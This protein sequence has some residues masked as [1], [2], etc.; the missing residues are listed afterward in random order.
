M[1]KLELSIKT[2]K[3]VVNQRYWNTL[4]VRDLAFSFTKSLIYWTVNIVYI[5]P[6][7][8]SS[9]AVCCFVWFIISAPPWVTRRCRLTWWQLTFLSVTD[10]I[11]LG[12]S[13][14]RCC[15]SIRILKDVMSSLFYSPSQLAG[16][17]H[18]PVNVLIKF[19]CAEHFFFLK[20]IYAMNISIWCCC[21]SQPSSVHCCIVYIYFSLYSTSVIWKG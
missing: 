6:I 7:S 20:S 12:T 21:N 11:L 14:P 17:T 15:R 5:D 1:H 19:Y 10:V 13:S 4:K 16:R 3:L 8:A 18:N 9:H 2:C